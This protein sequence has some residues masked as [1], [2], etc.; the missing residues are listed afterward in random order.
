MGKDNTVQEILSTD[1]EDLTGKKTQ[2]GDS[3][4]EEYGKKLW[5]SAP[6]GL[7]LVLD[8]LIYRYR[9]CAVYITCTFYITCE[10]AVFGRI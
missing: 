3:D 10:L 7:V 8:G 2:A 5:L 1:A 6:G 4:D 9:V